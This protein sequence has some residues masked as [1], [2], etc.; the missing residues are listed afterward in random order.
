MLIF[1]LGE[2]DRNLQGRN[3][4]IEHA[5]SGAL[6]GRTIYKARILSK[7]ETVSKTGQPQRAMQSPRIRQLK[8][9]WTRNYARTRIRQ[10]GIQAQDII[11]GKDKTVRYSRARQY[12]G[13]GWDSI[14]G[15]ESTQDR[16]A[17]K[18]ALQKK[19]TVN[20]GLTASDSRTASKDTNVSKFRSVPNSVAE[21]KL[22]V[23]APAPAPT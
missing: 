13:H 17:K 10:S 21:P 16:L 7:G 23:S 2:S 22:F 14:Q 6:F 3:Q 20:N 19:S 18:R 15:E 12:S 5:V 4:W 1:S 8:Y 9:P 11:E